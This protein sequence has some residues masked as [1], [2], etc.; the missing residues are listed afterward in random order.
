MNYFYGDKFS[1]FKMLQR[2]Y[3]SDDVIRN[4]L[5]SPIQSPQA[6]PSNEMS[7]LTP[8]LGLQYFFRESLDLLPVSIFIIPGR[9][10]A[11]AIFFGYDFH[12]PFDWKDIL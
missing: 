5:Q 3:R 8:G 12:D 4:I 7:L 10:G 1:Y 2:T 11:F 9:I 6:Y